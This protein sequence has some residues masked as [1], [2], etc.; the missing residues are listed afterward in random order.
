MLQ[1]RQAGPPG[2]IWPLSGCG[3]ADRAVAN[4]A[5]ALSVWTPLSMLLLTLLPPMHLLPRLLPA[6]ACL[7]VLAELRTPPLLLHRARTARS[8]RA[9]RRATSAASPATRRASARMCSDRSADLFILQALDGERGSRPPSW[10]HVR[11]RLHCGVLCPSR[12]C[13]LFPCY[14]ECLKDVPKAR[15]VLSQRVLPYCPPRPKK[16]KK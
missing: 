1:L 16:V 9:T 5:L 12:E 13:Y 3:V 8:P 14:K 4:A 11:C 15:R 7:L 6:N 2:A 10:A